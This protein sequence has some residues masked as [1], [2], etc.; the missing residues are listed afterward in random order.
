MI[1]N[2]FQL[3]A[4]KRIADFLIGKNLPINFKIESKL[5]DY[6]LDSKP[7][8][9]LYLSIPSSHL[10]LWIYDDELEYRYFDEKLICEKPDYESEDELLTNFL[11]C[12][13]ALN[14][15]E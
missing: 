15:N 4:K 10:E 8:L 13:A 3:K 7:E 11:K 5:V 2:K 12:L 14:L 1:E 6:R 9:F